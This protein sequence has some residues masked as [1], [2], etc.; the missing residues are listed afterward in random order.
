MDVDS[1][2]LHSRAPSGNT[3]IELMNT[4]P[5]EHMPVIFEKITFSD[6]YVDHGVRGAAP[7]SLSASLLC[8]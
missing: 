1:T 6:D 2:L 3:C 8:V 5:V 7:S 4:Y